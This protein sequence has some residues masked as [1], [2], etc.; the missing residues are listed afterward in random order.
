MADETHTKCPICGARAKPLDRT[1]DAAGFDCPNH[2]RFKVT[3]SV[4]AVRN[5]HTRKQW[6]AALK[7]AKLKAKP[8]VW[9]VITT[10]DF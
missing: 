2:D 7:R 8:G 3:D 9:P 5:E 10:Y 4:F 6:E 1:G